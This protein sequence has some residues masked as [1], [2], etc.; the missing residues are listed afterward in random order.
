MLG[1]AQ[2][3]PVLCFI[4]FGSRRVHLGGCTSNPIGAWSRTTCS[5]RTTGYIGSDTEGT[6]IPRP[7]RCCLDPRGRHSPLSASAGYP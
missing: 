4:E 7:K 6:M 5:S 3:D 2:E 1:E